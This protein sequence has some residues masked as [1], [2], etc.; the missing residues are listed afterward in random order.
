MARE[1]RGSQRTV[2]AR[3]SA[4]RHKD[5]SLQSHVVRSGRPDDGPQDVTW[6]DFPV[7]QAVRLRIE[8]TGDDSDAVV[9]VY[10]DG[11][12][13]LQEVPM[14]SFGRTQS[15]LSLGVFVEGESGRRIELTVDNLEIV[16]RKS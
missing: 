8:R 14:S 13:V 7:D 10:V 12:P 3:V 15:D 16:R 6:L 9:N 5:G 2:T 1:N 11:T 4:S